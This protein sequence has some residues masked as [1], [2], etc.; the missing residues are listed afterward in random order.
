MHHWGDDWFKKHGMELNNA[1][2]ACEDVFR[3]FRIGTHGKEK[4]GCYR[5]HVYFWDGGIH[6]LIWPGYVRIVSSFL[7]WKVDELFLKKLTYY[8]GILYV[9]QKIQFAAYN[10]AFQR[11]CKKYPNVIDELV[12][13]I[14]YPELVKPGFFGKVDGRAIQKK[15]WS[16]E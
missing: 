9:G 3:I 10:Y 11:A 14:D 7:Y 15:Y 6:T 8:T 13:E 12:S 16:E 1:M 2:R 5:D 4:W